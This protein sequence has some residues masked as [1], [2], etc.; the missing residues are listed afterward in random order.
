MDLA[1]TTNALSRRVHNKRCPVICL[2]G[3][4]CQ[5]IRYGD[6]CAWEFLA[7]FRSAPFTPTWS[8]PAV[9]TTAPNMAREHFA[10]LE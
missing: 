5:R 10:I 4:E 2:V 6:W 8:C 9:P 7:W 3:G 1:G